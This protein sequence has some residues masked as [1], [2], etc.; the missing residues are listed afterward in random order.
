MSF[1]EKL[2]T[3]SSQP[4]TILLLNFFPSLSSD[5]VVVHFVVSADG[6]GVNDW[7][8][9][10]TLLPPRLVGDTLKENAVSG[11]CTYIGT[12]HIFWHLKKHTDTKH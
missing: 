2:K 5:Y 3:S 6:M 9:E 8:A 1:K 7:G 11:T 10:S 4:S 12:L